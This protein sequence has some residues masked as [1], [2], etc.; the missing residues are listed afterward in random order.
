MFAIL[1]ITLILSV[2]FS[3]SPLFLALFFVRL[4]TSLLL[5]IFR[6]LLLLLLTQ[7]YRRNNQYIATQGPTTTTLADFWR[8]VWEL[9]CPTI[10]M[11]TKLE[12]EDKVQK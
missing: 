9:D 7:G 10:V 2:F 11:V 12:E 3:R 4:V 5:S 1:V 8:M 6:S